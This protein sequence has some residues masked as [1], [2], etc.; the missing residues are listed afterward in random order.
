VS[1]PKPQQ[2]ARGPE[3]VIQA[4]KVISAAVAHSLALVGDTVS[5]PGLRVL[6]MLEEAGSL[7]LSAVADGL[8]VNASTASR[9][10]D[11]LVVD[12]LVDRREQAEDRRQVALSLTDRGSQFLRRVMREREA[13]L[14]RV[15]ETMP[16]HEQDTLIEGLAG[17]VA[18]AAALRDDQRP[19]RGHGDMIRWLL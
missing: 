16:R 6:V 12:G 9:T 17:F 3:V 5:A 2:A 10:C 4:S 14:M 1:A 19:D 15:V 18:A 13:V 11:R 7:N 8:G